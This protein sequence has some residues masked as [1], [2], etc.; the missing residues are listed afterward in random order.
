MAARRQLSSLG[1]SLRIFF[2]PCQAAAPSF[3]AN[4]AGQQLDTH[5]EEPSQPA[6]WGLQDSHRASQSAA[7]ACRAAMRSFASG[8]SFGSVGPVTPDQRAVTEA[9]LQVDALGIVKFPSVTLVH[10]AVD[11]GYS[12]C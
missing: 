8:S 1:P 4:W 6:A 11:P 10:T 5:S 7:W 3:S 12:C 2:N 9:V